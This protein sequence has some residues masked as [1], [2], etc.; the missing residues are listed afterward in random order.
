MTIGKFIPSYSYFIG[1]SFNQRVIARAFRP[2][3]SHTRVQN[4]N[5]IA[6]GEKPSQ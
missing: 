1:K 4:Q 6:S 5:E 3:Q 2:K